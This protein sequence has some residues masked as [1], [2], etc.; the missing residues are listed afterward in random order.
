MAEPPTQESE[1]PSTFTFTTPI[2][3]TDLR[4]SFAKARNDD[5][6]DANRLAQARQDLPCTHRDA[7]DPNPY[8]PEDLYEMLPKP[9]RALCGRATYE[10]KIQD[11][12]TQETGIN[13]TALNVV[14]ASD[15]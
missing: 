11:I 12:E 3:P 2:I 6:E 15:P 8:G 14:V 10:L 7:H 9:F 5:D 4:T 13:R 1:F